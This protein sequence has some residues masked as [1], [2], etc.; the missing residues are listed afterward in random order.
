VIVVDWK[1]AQEVSEV[2]VKEH[3]RG[4]LVQKTAQAFSISK[5]V[6]ESKYLTD[7]FVT[8]VC[9]RVLAFTATLFVYPIILS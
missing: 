4:S 6:F 5:I 3:H 7:E 9:N 8:T 2:D 1:M